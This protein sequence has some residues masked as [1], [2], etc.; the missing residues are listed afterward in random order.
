MYLLSKLRFER[1]TLAFFLSPILTGHRFAAP[2]AK[3]MY[4]SSFESPRLCSFLLCLIKSVFT[5]FSHVIL[6]KDTSIYIILI[7]KGTYLF[8]YGSISEEIVCRLYAPKHWTEGGKVLRQ[9]GV[10]FLSDEVE[11]QFCLSCPKSSHILRLLCR[12]SQNKS[13]HYIFKTTFVSLIF[14][15]VFIFKGWI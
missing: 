13:I 5:L 4:S 6:A 1:L 14:L 7:H 8:C 3:I 12:R 15:K 2:L 10:Y 9:F 11:I